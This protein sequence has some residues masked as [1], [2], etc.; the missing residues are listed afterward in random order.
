M[1]IRSDYVSNSS[2]ASFVIKKDAA[3]AVKM[4]IEDFGDC[5]DGSWATLGEN[6]NVG[7]LMKDDNPDEWLS[8]MAPE[9]FVAEFTVGE[10]D[11]DTDSRKEPK[12]PDNIVKF[13]FECDDYD[14][15]GMGYLVFLYK[16]FK[17]FGFHPDTTNSEK[18]FLHDTDSF[19]GRI[20]DKLERR[21]DN[22]NENQK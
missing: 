19:L 16:Y 2:S 14:K 3:K 4:F 7:Y 9:N 17:K 20:L 1:K 10:Y 21:K 6:M 22:G 12:N 18:D 11:Y 5:L 15:A 8:Y 13:G